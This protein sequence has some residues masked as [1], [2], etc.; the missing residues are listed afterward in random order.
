MSNLVFNKALYATAAFASMVK[1]P[2]IW[3]FARE[4]KKIRT[5]LGTLRLEQNKDGG[6]RIIAESEAYKHERDG[7][8]HA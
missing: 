2:T 8:G 6:F 5:G 4:A 1:R 7:L 3:D